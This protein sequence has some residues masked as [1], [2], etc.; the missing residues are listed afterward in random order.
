MRYRIFDKNNNCVKVFEDRED[1]EKH[2][3]GSNPNI[4]SSRDQ[5]VVDHKLYDINSYTE[6]RSQ[7]N[8]D[9]VFGGI[10]EEWYGHVK[11]AMA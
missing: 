10:D 1:F 7:G 8:S 9:N 6:F 4:P 11:V 5:I 2:F 3:R